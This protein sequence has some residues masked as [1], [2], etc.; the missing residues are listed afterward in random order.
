MFYFVSWLLSTQRILESSSSDD[1]APRI[2][3]D[4]TPDVIV[5][6]TIVLIENCAEEEGCNN[7]C[8][9]FYLVSWLISTQRI[10]VSS[11]SSD[12]EEYRK[13]VDTHF[14]LLFIVVLPFVLYIKRTTHHR[15]KKVCVKSLHSA[16][17]AYT[18]YN[19]CTECFS[20]R[21]SAEL[22]EAVS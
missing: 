2:K 17:V 3:V 4:F 22:R 7:V 21:A 6:C 19:P 13:Q 10:V 9:M 12:D 16:Y 11:D 1:E 14:L 5:V 20:P 15:R 18:F 8:L